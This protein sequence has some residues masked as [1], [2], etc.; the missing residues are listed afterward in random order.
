MLA[1][2]LRIGQGHFHIISHYP[3]IWCYITSAVT[4]IKVEMLKGEVGLKDSSSNHPH[5]ETIF[6]LLYITCVLDRASSSKQENKAT[7]CIKEVSHR[8]FCSDMKKKIKYK[9]KW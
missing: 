3:A 6:N 1:Y 7:L 9:I 5:T 4:L 2:D 8:Q